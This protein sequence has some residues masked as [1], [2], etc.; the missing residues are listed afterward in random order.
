MVMSFADKG[1]HSGKCTVF[2]I[3]TL[4]GAPKL[5][6]AETMFSSSKFKFLVTFLKKKKERKKERKRKERNGDEYVL[7]RKEPPLTKRCESFMRKQALLYRNK[8]F[9][10]EGTYKT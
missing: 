3:G 5:Q 2:W 6:Q 8:V 10:K 9:F 7:R 4:I 1:G